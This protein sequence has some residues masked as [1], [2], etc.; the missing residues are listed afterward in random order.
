MFDHAKNTAAVS[1]CGLDDPGSSAAATCP[2]NHFLA[3]LRRPG[4]QLPSGAVS[5]RAGLVPKFTRLLAS[6]VAG[7]VERLAGACVALPELVH[8]VQVCSLLAG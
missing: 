7:L 2:A 5:L 8:Q 3:L 6:D 4:V 1:I